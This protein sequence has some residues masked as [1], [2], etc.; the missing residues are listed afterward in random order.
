M[1][2][3]EEDLQI[4]LLTSSFTQE[5]TFLC[6]PDYSLGGQGAYFP[7]QIVASYGQVSSK[8]N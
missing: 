6:G 3:R 7:S 2:G 8:I 4:L 5:T 1:G